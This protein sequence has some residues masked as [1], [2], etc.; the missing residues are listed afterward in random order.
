MKIR[1]FSVVQQNFTQFTY[2]AFI[3][4]GIEIK[5]KRNKRNWE[6]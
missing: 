4:T 1:I 2:H 6:L 5:N 3:I